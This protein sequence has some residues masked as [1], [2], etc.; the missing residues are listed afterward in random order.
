MRGCTREHGARDGEAHD[1]ALGAE[2]PREFEW[3]GAAS[4]AYVERTFTA[5]G[6]DGRH[7]GQAE[8]AQLAVEHLLQAHPFRA[9]GLVPML[10]LMLV[11]RHAGFRS[12]NSMA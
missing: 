3:A 1:A 2:P 7:R 11:R 10:D 5:R 9:G 8:V 6:G 12:I 4:A